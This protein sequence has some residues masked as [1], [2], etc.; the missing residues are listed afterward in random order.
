MAKIAA[1]NHTGK[2]VF[3]Q[4]YLAHLKE[5]GHEI[6]RPVTSETDLLR[7]ICREKYDLVIAHPA[8]WRLDQ[9]AEALISVSDEIHGTAPKLLYISGAA[10]VYAE[11]LEHLGDPEDLEDLEY[12]EGL[13]YPEDFENPKYSEMVFEE[14]GLMFNKHSGFYFF[15]KGYPAYPEEE[16]VSRAVDYLTKRN[17]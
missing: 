7:K 2:P 11:D 16:N 8:N 10:P 17:I 3:Y 4:H 14:I 15:A 1:L 12:S 5:E 9:L 6:E 13:E